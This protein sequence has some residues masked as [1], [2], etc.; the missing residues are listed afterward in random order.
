ME[1]PFI[2]DEHLDACEPAEE[3]EGTNTT[4]TELPRYMRKDKGIGLF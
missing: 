1:R 2:I 4:G 3:L